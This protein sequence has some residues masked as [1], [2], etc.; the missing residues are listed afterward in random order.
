MQWIERCRS[1]F[2]PCIG[3]DGEVYVC[4][5]H[6]GHKERSYGNLNDKS[7]SEIWS[8]MSKRKCVMNKIETEEKFSMCSQL[9]KPHESNKVFWNIKKN[10]KKPGLISSLKVRSKKIEDKILHKNFI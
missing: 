9:C 1:Q 4:T 8:D 7:F 5:S 10:Y 6:R 2:Q 3:A